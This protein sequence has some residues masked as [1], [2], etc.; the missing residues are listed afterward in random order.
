MC[1]YIY[2]KMCIYTY[3]HMDRYIYI[4]ICVCIKKREVCIHTYIYIHIHIYIYM[5]IA[6]CEVPKRHQTII[7][8]A[9]R[10]AHCS[11]ICFRLVLHRFT[12]CEPEI[13]MKSNDNE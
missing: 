9:F 10:V 6:L 12:Q 1:I 8:C 7:E 2:I 4:Y 3:T 5:Y 13:P 11:I